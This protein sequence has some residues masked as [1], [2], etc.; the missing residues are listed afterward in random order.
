M[1]MAPRAFLN[2]FPNRHAASR[3]GSH[4]Q[5]IS[6]MNMLD[7]IYIGLTIKLVHGNHVFRMTVFYQFQIAKFTFYRFLRG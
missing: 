3:Q 6:Q 5:K 2:I 1:R 7:T 4:F